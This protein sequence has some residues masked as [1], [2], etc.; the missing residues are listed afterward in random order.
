MAALD[1]GRAVLACMR[2]VNG[3]GE[4]SGWRHLGPCRAGLCSWRS[5]CSA[6][7]L[8]WRRKR[9]S[10]PRP[11][12]WRR[13]GPYRAGPRSWHSSS[14]SALLPAVL[15]E[16]RAV[17]LVRCIPGTPTL[18]KVNERTMQLALELGALVDAEL[19]WRFPDSPSGRSDVGQVDVGRLYL[20]EQGRPGNTASCTGA[21]VT[22]T[23]RGS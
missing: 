12:G 16:D 4:F 7:L 20:R 17:A 5:E 14:T 9:T 6:V 19:L 10:G 8:R 23:M 15:E 11:E 22:W 1:A 21:T 2:P 13:P 3:D 18:Q